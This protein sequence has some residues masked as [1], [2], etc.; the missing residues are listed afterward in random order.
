MKRWLNGGLVSVAIALIFMLVA[1]T[2]QSASAPPAAVP[3]GTTAPA[4]KA[5]PVVSAEQAAWDKV[6]EAAKKEGRLNFY[7]FYFT[8]DKG[9]AMANAFEN[10]YGIKLDIITGRGS[11]FTERLKT[12]QRMGQMTGDVV[13][14]SSTHMENMRQAGL[15]IPSLDLP[16]LNEKDVWAI[17]P[18]FHN[19]EGYY[20]DYQRYFLTTFINTN[21][22]KP[23]EEPKSFADLLAPKWKGNLIMADPVLSESPSRFVLFIQ[24]KRL[25]EDYPTRL[26]QQDLKF[27]P[28]TVGAVAKLARGEAA[29]TVFVST[30]EAIQMAAEGAPIRIVDMKEGTVTD[31]EAMGAIKGSPHPNAAKVFLNFIYSQEGQKLLGEKIKTFPVRKGIIANVPQAIQLEP[32]NPLVVDLEGVQMTAKAFR[33]KQFVSQLKP[34]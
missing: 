16:V 26:G 28:S 23:G 9:M 21:L 11:E 15:L 5:A 19:K 12:E 1:C 10:R 2:P 8:G 4:A 7:T 30:M 13:A 6:V 31:T 18:T 27:D 22:V 25:S 3:Q 17:H 32:S 24:Q 33:D 20:L 14:T 29:A 34:K